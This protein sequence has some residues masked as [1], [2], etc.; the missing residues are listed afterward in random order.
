MARIANK[1][2]YQSNKLLFFQGNWYKVAWVSDTHIC[3]CLPGEQPNSWVHIDSKAIFS[4]P[5]SWVL[6]INHP[7]VLVF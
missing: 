6:P 3:L 7:E 1:N 2:D 5:T 4:K